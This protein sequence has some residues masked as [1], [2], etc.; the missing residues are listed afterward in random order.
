MV[1]QVLDV[2]DIDIIVV[3]NHGLIEVDMVELLSDAS[4]V[5]NGG[6]I[7]KYVVLIAPPTAAEDLLEDVGEFVG[8]LE[9]G[10]VLVNLEE[11]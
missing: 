1:D 4:L 6:L 7:V 2:V 3:L 5:R 8:A 9:D 10:N 11:V